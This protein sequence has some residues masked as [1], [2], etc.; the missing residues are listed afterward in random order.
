MYREAAHAAACAGQK[1]TKQQLQR[2][3]DDILLRHK[4]LQ[5]RRKDLLY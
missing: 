1:R 5:A 2:D 3:E 4:L